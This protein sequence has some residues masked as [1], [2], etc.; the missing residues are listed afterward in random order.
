VLGTVQGRV[1]DDEAALTSSASSWPIQP[2]QDRGFRE[3]HVSATF[4]ANF[5]NHEIKA[6]AAIT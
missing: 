6:G 1:P 3:G 5:H 2:F 4:A